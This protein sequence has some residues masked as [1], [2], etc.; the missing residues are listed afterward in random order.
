MTVVLIKGDDPSLVAQALQREV[1]ELLGDGDR[2]LMVEEVAEEHYFGNRADAVIDP[3][4]YAAHTPGF[5]TP[6]RIVIGRNLAMFTK[7]DQVAPLVRWLEAPLE[8]T[9]LVLVWEKSSASG[10]RMGAIPKSLKDAIKAAGGREVD[11][12]PSGK[13]RKALV[14]QRLYDAPLRFDPAARN[15]IIDHLGD[16]AGRVQPIVEA[17]ISSFGEGAALGLA[18]VEPFLGMASDVPP[19]ELTD[20]IDSGDIAL[21][22]N[23][24]DRM[25]R[26]G[27]RHALQIMATLHGHYQRALALDGLGLNNE[28]AAADVLGIKGSTFPAKKAMTL[29]RKLGHERLSEITLLLA[30]ADL[31]LRGAS[32]MPHDAVIEVLIARLARISR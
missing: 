17:L 22:L 7:A 19:W 26:G 8:T 3:L 6:R 30:Q 9:D 13:G 20:A 5:L 12:A 10:A 31:D 29:A 2:S 27:E 28:K 23:K 11:A 4:V 15:R 14:E 1:K 32:A 21:A 24:A 16:D 18:D 25:V